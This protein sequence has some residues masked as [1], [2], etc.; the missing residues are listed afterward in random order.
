MML[1]NSGNYQENLYKYIVHKLQQV[2]NEIHK[3]YKML[4]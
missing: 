1:W 4:S 3:I 2:Q